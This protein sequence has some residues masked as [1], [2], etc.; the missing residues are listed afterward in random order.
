MRRQQDGSSDGKMI[1]IA[2][3]FPQQTPWSEK[4]IMLLN[5]MFQGFETHFLGKGFRL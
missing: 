4:N 3:F 2:H 5:G 1:A